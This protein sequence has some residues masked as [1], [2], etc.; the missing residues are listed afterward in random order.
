MESFQKRN[1]FEEHVQFSWKQI[2]I[3]FSDHWTS[4]SRWSEPSYTIFAFS[5]L[6]TGTSERHNSTPGQNVFPDCVEEIFLIKLF[7][8]FTTSLFHFQPACQWSGQCQRI[9]LEFWSKQLL[10]SRLRPK[11]Y[12]PTVRIIHILMMFFTLFLRWFGS[13]KWAPSTYI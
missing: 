7:L 5:S 13:Q 3:H 12:D 6:S 4:S 1:A 9:L 8:F 10:H 2:V 11:I